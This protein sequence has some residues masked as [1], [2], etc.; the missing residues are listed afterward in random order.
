MLQ[1]LVFL[2]VA[3][4]ALTLPA[5][6]QRGGR[7]GPIDKDKLCDDVVRANQSIKFRGVQ[8]ITFQF[9]RD[10]KSETRKIK[11]LVVRDGAKSRS[12]QIMDDDAPGSISVDDG[13]YRLQFDPK[14]NV[15]NKSPSLQHQNS[16]RLEMLMRDRRSE[17]EINV[18]ESGKV[19][20]YPTYLIE[21]KDKRGFQH[22]IWVDRRGKAILKREM[23]GPDPNRGVSFV[24]TTF[25]YLRSVEASEFTI[26]KPG[27]KVLEPLDRLIAAAKKVEYQP[28]RVVGDSKF[29]L[30]ESFGFSAG[31][32]DYLRSTYSDGRMVLSLVQ[33]RGELDESKLRLRGQ[34]SYTIHVWKKDGYAF[35]L[36][37]SLT[38]SELERLA[39]LVR[40]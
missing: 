8:V 35:A 26:N 15:I 40:R 20:D 14:N 16:E 13:K 31:G 33:V 21:L 29:Q 38:S 28:Y 12:E 39:K 22:R 9:S 37:G 32:D 34:E 24:F 4:G 36:I 7:S 23:N 3:L 27:V 17:Y 30:Y 1:R 11:E 25:R 5:T 19:A 10:G 6:A 2:V 18:S